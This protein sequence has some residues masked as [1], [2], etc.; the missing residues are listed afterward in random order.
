MKVSPKINNVQDLKVEIIRLKVL[1]TQQEA[2]LVDQYTLL[3]HKV[4]KPMRVFNNVVSYVPGV[5]FVKG[6]MSMRKP[7]SA[8]GNA[9]WLTKG[10]RLGMPLLLNRTLLKRA[11]WLKKTLVMLASDG[12]VGQINQ[13][14]FVSA[15]EGISN[16]IKP[17]SKKKRKEALS[18]KEATLPQ[19][20]IHG[21]PP[22][23]ESF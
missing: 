11:G 17:K 21:I 13:N 7:S 16:F 5:D 19:E 14:R 18:Q 9:D 10:L 1:K 6:V 15:I 22:E 2:Y 23:S 20:S 4:E 3:K 12:A 8:D